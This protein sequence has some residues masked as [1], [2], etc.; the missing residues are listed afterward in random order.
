MRKL[1]K[2]KAVTT[3]QVANATNADPV[4]RNTH[5]PQKKKATLRRC[6]QKQFACI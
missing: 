2:L 6:A 3:A 1:V 4:E 5:P